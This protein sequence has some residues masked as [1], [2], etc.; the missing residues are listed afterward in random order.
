MKKII[1]VAVCA[2]L[3]T[4][5]AK[6]QFYVGGQVGIDAANSVN[7][8]IRPEVGYNISDNFAVGAVL[9][10]GF[11]KYDD[12]TATDFSISPYA[13]YTFVKLGPASLFV[14]GMVD[15]YFSTT[16]YEDMDPSNDFQWGVGLAPGVAIPLTEKFSFVGHVGYLGY[17]GGLFRANLDFNTFSAGLYYSF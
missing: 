12:H 3:A 4:F 7:L 17:I 16:K 15:L 13:R 11:D 8:S 9:G 14:D 5:S 6:A 10:L 1:L 2:I